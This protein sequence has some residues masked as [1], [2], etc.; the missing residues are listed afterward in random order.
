MK[1]MNFNMKKTILIVLC[2]AMIIAALA[3]CSD[4]DTAAPENEVNGESSTIE[5]SPDAFD[6]SPD[7]FDDNEFRQGVDFEAAFAAFPPD[8]PMI[9]VNGYIATWAELF[10]ILHSG[11]NNLFIVTEE[12]PDWTERMDDG[13]TLG[14]IMLENAVADILMFR[15]LAYGAE[16]L[17]VTFNDEE[18][19]LIN[20][21]LEDLILQ[22][23]GEEQLGAM[24]WMNSGISSIGLFKYLITTEFLYSPI[25]RALY[26]EDAEMLPDEKI[27]AFVEREEYLMAMHIL[28]EKTGDDEDSLAFLEDLLFQLENYDGEDIEVF[29]SELMFEHSDD[30]GGLSSYPDGYLFR[31]GDMVSEFESAFLELE[32]G[33]F[34]GVVESDFGYHIILRLPVNPDTIPIGASMTDDTR[35]LRQLAAFDFFFELV[36]E[37]R[38]NL[39]HEFTAEFMSI[40]YVTIF[41]WH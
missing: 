2:I 41:E 22:I 19:Q 15:A 35:T 11:I 18:Q 8:T 39:T 32:F 23:G 3:G 34:S 40:D 24:L 12:F 10:A 6:D 14:E 36:S 38:D 5:D 37:W 7:A 16:L 30:F 33:E 27:A 28:R 31:P 1:G 4:Q 26:G 17:D 20:D 13:K 21:Y 25:M 29:F 9:I